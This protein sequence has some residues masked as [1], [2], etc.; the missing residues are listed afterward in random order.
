[1][2]HSQDSDLNCPKGCSTPQI[3]MVSGETCGS[4]PGA[5]L[6]QGQ[7]GHQSADGEQ[8]YWELL[9]SLGVYLSL[10]CIFIT[11]SNSGRFYHVFIINLFIHQLTKST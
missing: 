8:L 2:E 11:I 9:V 1:M 3:L 7:A 4:W 10:A 6:A 5:T